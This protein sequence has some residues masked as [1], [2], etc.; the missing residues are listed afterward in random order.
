LRRC[1]WHATQEQQQLQNSFGS[2]AVAECRKGCAGQ[3][4][5]GG[6]QSWHSGGHNHKQ[7]GVGSFCGRNAERAG[8]GSTKAGTPY[9][10]R[11]ATRGAQT[12]AN[13]KAVRPAFLALD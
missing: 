13:G 4:A 7:S 3:G 1:E 9:N 11:G 6:D 8:P 12:K 10:G 5:Q 2:Q